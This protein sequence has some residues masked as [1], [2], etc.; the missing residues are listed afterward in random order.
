V[1]DITGYVEKTQEIVRQKTK[2]SAKNHEE[3]ME[4]LGEA[5]LAVGKTLSKI[6]EK[7]THHDRLIPQSFI[8]PHSP[9]SIISPI[10]ILEEKTIE[11]K[12]P[13]HSQ[14]KY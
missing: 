14:R 2:D 10:Y 13:T 8:L 12:F 6:Q 7:D 1:T 3:L 9:I 4:G 5:F 11:K